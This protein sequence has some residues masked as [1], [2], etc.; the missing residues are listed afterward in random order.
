MFRLSRSRP[1]WDAER[2]GRPTGPFVQS[3]TPCGSREG[4]VCWPR[5]E[6]GPSRLPV[7]APQLPARVNV[8]RLV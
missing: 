1:R 4:G 5:R 7:N 2:N 8:E 3:G 6:A